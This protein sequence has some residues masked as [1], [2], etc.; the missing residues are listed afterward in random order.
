MSKILNLI[1]GFEY[2]VIWDD[3][4][5]ADIVSLVHDHP[6]RWQHASI[7]IISETLIWIDKNVDY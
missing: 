5:T 6:A 3:K 1:V 4:K 2:L 7:M